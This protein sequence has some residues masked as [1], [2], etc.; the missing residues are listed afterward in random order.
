MTTIAY[1]NGIMA[2]D[3]RAYSGD[4]RPIGSKEKVK[5]LSNGGL[6]A[7]TSVKPGLSERFFRLVDSTGVTSDFSEDFDITA[8]VVLPSG[9]VYYYAGSKSFSGPLTGE[10]FA[11]GSGEDYAMAAMEMGA[12]PERAVEVATKFDVFSAPPVTVMRL[13]LH[14]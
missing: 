6:F 11:I 2:A 8:L 9:E 13:A 3:S 7:A 1:R 14:E 10:Y 4:R 12:G 5:R